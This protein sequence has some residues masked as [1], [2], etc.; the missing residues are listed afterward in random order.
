MSVITGIKLQSK[1]KMKLRVKY[2][3]KKG[4]N[5][6]HCTIHRLLS[7]HEVYAPKFSELHSSHTHLITFQ[8]E[9]DIPP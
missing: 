1:L 5:S 2:A 7:S 3:C 6:H 9:E 4:K 8:Q